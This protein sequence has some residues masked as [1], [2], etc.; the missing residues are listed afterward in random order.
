MFASAS[1]TVA[2]FT[3]ALSGWLATD[4]PELEVFGAVVV[5]HPIDVMDLFVWFKRPTE[6]LLHHHSVFEHIFSRGSAP[7]DRMV[8]G[9]P[10]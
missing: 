4:G 5:S 2:R 8:V 3:D 10:K 6:F 7:S 9:H 1:W